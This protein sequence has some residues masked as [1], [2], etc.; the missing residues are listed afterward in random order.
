MT[1]ILIITN[2]DLQ[3]VVPDKGNG[4]DQ[5]SRDKQIERKPSQSQ[6]GFEDIFEESEF[7]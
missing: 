3:I 7:S 1:E 6:E 2:H 5:E 4:P